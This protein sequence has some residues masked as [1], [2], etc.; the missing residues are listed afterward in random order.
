MGG[1]LLV[2]TIALTISSPL[3]LWA[4]F[5]AANLMMTEPDATMVF[6]LYSMFTLLIGVYTAWVAYV[7]W[8]LKSTALLSVRTYFGSL[9]VY[10]LVVALLRLLPHRTSGIGTEFL[11]STGRDAFRNI[12]YIAIWTTYL[13]KS[14]RVANTFPAATASN[15]TA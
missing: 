2:F 3:R 15:A 14:R 6:G 7:L 12:V 4:A 1:W 13:R 10:S 8:I 9:V 5:V 11:N